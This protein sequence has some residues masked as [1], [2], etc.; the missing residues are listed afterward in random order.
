M[1]VALERHMYGD[2]NRN[3]NRRKY[4]KRRAV[5]ALLLATVVL[6]GV[7][8]FVSKLVNLPYLLEGNQASHIEDAEHADLILSHHIG[9]NDAFTVQFAQHALNAQNKRDDQQAVNGGDATDGKQEQA[10]VEGNQQSGSGQGEAAPVQQ[11]LKYAA[12][13]FDDGPDLKYTTAILD[14]LKDKNVK[15]TFFVVGLQVGKYPEILQR[16]VDEGHAVGNHS[17]NHADLSKRSKAQ[18]LKEIEKAD[19]LIEDAVGFTPELFRAPYGAVSK[20]LHD[21]MKEKERQLI[22]WTVDTRDWAGTSPDDMREMIKSETKPGG[23]ILMHSF[24][25]KHIANTVEALPFIIDDLKELGY[26]LVTVNEL[27]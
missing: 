23:I 15:A 4:R 2:R 14:I 25:G 21:V 10:A 26:T 12:L 9:L 27:P 11:E 6:V 7:G 1:A 5:L 19:Q 16:I 13:T 22:G 3:R 24:G 20:T 17:Q 18:I 8:Y